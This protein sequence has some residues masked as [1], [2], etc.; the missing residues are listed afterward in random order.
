MAELKR[1]DRVN[2]KGGQAWIGFE[3]DGQPKVGMAKRM[4]GTYIWFIMEEMGQKTYLI[5]HPD[6]LEG[7]MLND[8]VGGDLEGFK[9][10]DNLNYIFATTMQITRY[11]EGDENKQPKKKLF[12]RQQNTEQ[13]VNQQQEQVKQMV[14]PQEQAQPQLY[15]VQILEQ[16]F[17][18][19]ELVAVHINELRSEYQRLNEV[20]KKQKELIDKLEKLVA[21]TEEQLEAEKKKSVEYEEGAK[22]EYKEKFTIPSSLDE[23]Q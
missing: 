1:G 4:V 3:E 11:Q 12:R 19:P 8:T 10:N 17:E 22:M 18:V 5:Q 14:T 23:E 15:R 9:V 7:K 13:V 21:N 6:G 20:V 2:F 16:V